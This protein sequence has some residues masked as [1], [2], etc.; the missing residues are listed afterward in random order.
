MWGNGISAIGDGFRDSRESLDVGFLHF[1]RRSLGIAF[2]DA[3][4]GLAEPKRAKV[5]WKV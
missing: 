1:R 2:H 4:A 3:R 5:S